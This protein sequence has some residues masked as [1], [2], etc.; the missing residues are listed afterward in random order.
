MKTGSFDLSG[1][2][3]LVTG[4]GQGVGREIART[5]AAHGAS[6]AINDFVA[7]RAEQVAAD[8][9]DAGGRAVGIQGDV[10]DAAAVAGICAQ[11]AEA[12]GPID[13]LV[14][15]AGNAGPQGAMPRTRFW[16]SDPADWDRYLRVNLHGVM[17]CSRACAATMV[18]RGWGRI[19]TIVSDAGRM[20][21]QGLEAY[22]AAKAGAAGFSRALARS[23]GRHGVTVNTIALSNIVRE[24]AQSPSGDEAEAIKRMLAHYI[25]RRQGRPDDVAPMVL[26]L[27]SDAGEWIT[28]QTYPVNGGYSLAL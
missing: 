4:A 5:L 11:V 13:I 17:L 25:V 6:V 1:H 24:G 27:A 22:S 8:I 10:A 12:L 20:G 3:A 26:L 7:E 18:E 14:N 28:G 2:V 21:E 16:E 23:L 19:V 15:N 9:R